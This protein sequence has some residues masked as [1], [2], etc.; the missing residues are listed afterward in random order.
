M[1][2]T[3]M[4]EFVI[5]RNGDQLTSRRARMEVGEDPGQALHL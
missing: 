3:S 5:Y 2:F 1:I 4:R